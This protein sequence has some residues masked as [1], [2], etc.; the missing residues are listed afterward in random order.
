VEEDDPAPVVW[1]G[2]PRGERQPVGVDLESID[3]P[4][5]IPIPYGL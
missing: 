5:I 3:H 2:G 1:T 4:V